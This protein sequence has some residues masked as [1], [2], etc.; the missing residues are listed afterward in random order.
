M[1]LFTNNNTSV[2]LY[3]PSSEKITTIG[4]GIIETRMELPAYTCTIERDNR[5]IYDSNWHMIGIPSYSDKQQTLNQDNLLYYYAFDATTNK[6]TV[7]STKGSEVTFKSMHSYLV[8]FAGT[9]NWRTTWQLT[10]PQGLAARRD[11]DSETDF[12]SLRLELQH[13]GEYAD[14]TFVQMQSEQATAEYDMNIDLTKFM[15]AGANIYTLTSDENIQLA[16]NVLPFAQTTIALGVVTTTDGEYTFTMPEGTD[17][18]MVE[19][20]DYVENTTTN[21]LFNDYIVNLPAGTYENRFALHIQPSKVVTDVDNM[22]DTEHGTKKYIINGQL[23]IQT[24]EGIFNA[25]GTRL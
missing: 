11:T 2:S 15:N 19:L 25:Q 7:T 23:I 24:S 5:K 8:Q 12:R 10:E 14:Q 17:G 1:G 9:I 6:Y 16:G 4:Q 18:M 20:I 3:F 22:L 21:L 13:N